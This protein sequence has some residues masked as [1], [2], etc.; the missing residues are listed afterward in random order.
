MNPP[1]YGF[2]MPRLSFSEQPSLSPYP[3]SPAEKNEA[4]YSFTSIQFSEWKSCTLH[5][6]KTSRLHMKKI[7][8]KAD[9]TIKT[10]EKT[11]RTSGLILMPSVSSSKNLSKP[12]LAA[13]IGPVL[14]LFFLLI[15]LI[16]F[17]A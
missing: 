5:G 1:E 9:M 11:R 14:S 12:A 7:F 4:K 6:A 15:L 10:T 17:F 2:Q 13:G 3:K 8:A 16:L